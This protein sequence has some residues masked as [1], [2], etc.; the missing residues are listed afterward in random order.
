MVEIN[1]SDSNR[2][3]TSPPHTVKI[4]VLFVVYFVKFLLTAFLQ[5]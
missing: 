5:V 3:Q 2:I 4:I 1:L